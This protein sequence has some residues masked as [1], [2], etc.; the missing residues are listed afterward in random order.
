MTYNRLITTREAA[1]VL[2]ISPHGVRDLIRR[3]VLESWPVRGYLGIER[4]GVR[5]G[6]VLAYAESRQPRGRRVA[7]CLGRPKD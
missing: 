5:C 2:G 3:G 1:A 4:H 7:V 6:A